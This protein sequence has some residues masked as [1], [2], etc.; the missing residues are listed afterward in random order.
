VKSLLL[1]GVPASEDLKIPSKIFP[2]SN[3]SFVANQN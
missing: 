1:V 3:L 2:D